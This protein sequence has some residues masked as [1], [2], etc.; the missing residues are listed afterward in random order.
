MTDEQKEFYKLFWSTRKYFSDP[1]SI[2]QNENFSDLQKG[3]KVIFEKF[4]EITKH[5]ETIAGAKSTEMAGLK[6]KAEAMDTDDDKAAKKILNEINND[7]RFPRLLTS[8]KLLDLE[9]EDVRFRRNVILQFLILFQ[10]L[11]GFSQN[12]KENTRNLLAARGANKQSLIQPSY[13]VTDEQMEWVKEM[14]TSL[15]GLLRLMKPHGSLYTDIVMIVL[16]HER[17]WI[18]WKA[19]GCP[20]FEKTPL[21]STILKDFRIKRM[22]V[23]KNPPIPY[24]Y[25]YGNIEMTNMY[26][27]PKEPL[28]SIMYSR[29][30]MPTPVVVI[31]QALKVLEKEKNASVEERFNIANGAL[32]QATRILYRSH[33]AL[34][35]KVYHIKKT[36]FNAMYQ[37]ES[38]DQE[39]GMD[40]DDGDSIEKGA[41]EEKPAKVTSPVSE[42]INEKRVETEIKVLEECKRFLMEDGVM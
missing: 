34:I 38:T 22:K 39:D 36:F 8:R 37:N 19:S 20:V 7:Y 24:R 28:S 1:P 30:A 42:I 11:S 18:I 40:E 15:T 14:E 3:A 27:K 32:F 5:E 4:Q 13:T 29:Q 16:K 23:L 12:E 35:P 26:A 41:I 31:E 21:D 10:Y 2:F 17:N 25:A 9:I 6:R 33:A